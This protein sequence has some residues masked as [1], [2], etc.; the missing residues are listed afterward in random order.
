[1]VRHQKQ[2]KQKDDDNDD[3]DDDSVCASVN[4]SVSLALNLPPSYWRWGAGHWIWPTNENK[5]ARREG[6]GKR[7]GSYDHQQR[8]RDNSA[9]KWQCDFATHF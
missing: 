2:E 6:G 3:D 1:M 7:S 4:V 8:Q 9:R 5:L